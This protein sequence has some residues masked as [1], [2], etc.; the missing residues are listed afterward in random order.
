MLTAPQDW[1][2]KQPI[3][4]KHAKKHKGDFDLLIIHKHY[5][6]IVAEIKTVGDNF[7]SLGLT[8]QNQDNLVAVKVQ[9]MVKQL[10][11]AGD[12]LSHLVSD[13][14]HKICALCQ[15]LGV[16]GWARPADYCLCAD[17]LTNKDEPYD[18]NDDVIKR[19]KKW[20]TKLCAEYC[21]SLA[22]DVYED[23][24]AREFAEFCTELCRRVSALRLWAASMYYDR[25]PPGPEIADPGSSDKYAYDSEDLFDEAKDDVGNVTP[26]SGVVRGLREAGV[27]VRVL[28]YGD[29]KAMRDVAVME[30]GDEVVAAYAG[31]VSGLER[32]VVVWL[33]VRRTGTETVDEDFGRLMAISRTTAQLVRVD[34]PWDNHENDD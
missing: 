8:E 33:Q 5:G 24:V 4:L 27:P 22:D 28:K 18:V 15:C 7:H 29:S 2:T 19:L 10:D 23:L 14:H 32:P 30:G 16:G 1:R 31:T 17:D 12:V 11:K 25:I 6:L 13:K 9:Q 26:A 20:W 3:D 21:P 34:W